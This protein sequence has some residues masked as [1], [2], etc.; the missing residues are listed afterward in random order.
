MVNW[1]KL[2]E[3]PG[4]TTESRRYWVSAEVRG[5]PREAV[6]PPVLGGRRF[7]LPAVH[8]LRTGLSVW[9]HGCAFLSGCE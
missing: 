7:C 2:H 3:V 5:D 1:L 4:S 9:L 8:L 6:V